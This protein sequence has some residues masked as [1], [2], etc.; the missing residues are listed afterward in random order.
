M[1]SVGQARRMLGIS[2]RTLR[3]YTQDGK[4][5][6]QRGPSSRRIFRRG[7]LDALS[8]LC[9]TEHF[10]ETRHAMQYKNAP[11]LAPRQHLRRRIPP[12]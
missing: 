8:G 7:D 9:R 12:R 11:C 1:L 4:L 10:R 6:D 2:S 5:P 3:Q